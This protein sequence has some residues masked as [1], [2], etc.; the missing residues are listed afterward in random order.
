MKAASSAAVTTTANRKVFIAGP[1]FGNA[2]YHSGVDAIRIVA[3]GIQQAR[4][5]GSQ[6]LGIAVIT[7]YSSFLEYLQPDTVSILIQGRIVAQGG[8]ELA[9][10]IEEKGF[11]QLQEVPA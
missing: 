4:R 8:K 11:E 7:H 6:H 2:Q 10:K 5:N 1:L 9:K 3:E